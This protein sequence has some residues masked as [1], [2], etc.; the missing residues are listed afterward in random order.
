MRILIAILGLIVFFAVYI[1]FDSYFHPIQRSESS[2]QAM[3]VAA[4]KPAVPGYFTAWVVEGIV[5]ALT[6]AM[7]SAGGATLVAVPFSMFTRSPQGDFLSRTQG[8]AYQTGYSPVPSSGSEFLGRILLM[9]IILYAV[10]LGLLFAGYDLTY[11]Y[12]WVAKIL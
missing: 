9:M 12:L 4:S 5:V 6:C 10:R 7:F 3:E 8:V 2:V 1:G 11:L